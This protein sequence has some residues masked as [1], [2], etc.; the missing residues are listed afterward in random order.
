MEHTK[1][2][3]VENT[4]ADKDGVVVFGEDEEFKKIALRFYL[5]GNFVGQICQYCNKAFDT[6]ES[7]DESVM[8]FG[9]RIA[10]RTCFFT[11]NPDYKRDAT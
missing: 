7:L 6:V 8:D 1:N 4:T 2:S 5:R 10:H 11:H 9:K 3:T